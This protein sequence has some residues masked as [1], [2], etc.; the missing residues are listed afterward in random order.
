MTT[1]YIDQHDYYNI[2]SIA[3]QHYDREIVFSPGCKYAVVLPSFYGDIYTTHKTIEAALKQ[4]R[5]NYRN[6]S[7][8]GNT[9]EIIDTEGNQYDCCGGYKIS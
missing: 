3:N 1:L 2:Y 7:F 6:Q 9:G 5:K 8:D 4:A